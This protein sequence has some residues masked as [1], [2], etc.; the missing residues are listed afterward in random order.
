MDEYEIAKKILV[1][2]AQSLADLLENVKSNPQANSYVM[3]IEDFRKNCLVLL[4]VSQS[5]ILDENNRD[6]LSSSIINDLLH[7]AAN[8]EKYFEQDSNFFTF[9]CT[10]DEIMK[11]LKAISQMPELKEYKLLEV[12][13]DKMFMGLTTEQLQEVDFRY[14]SILKSQDSIWNITGYPDGSN[15]QRLQ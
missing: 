10:N 14:P 5:I 13:G 11:A 1:P 7:F 2:Y 9:L 3:V 8:Y 4:K 6:D 12:Q 15:K